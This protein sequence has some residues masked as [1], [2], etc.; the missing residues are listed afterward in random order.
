MDIT[1]YITKQNDMAK[2]DSVSEFN[3]HKAHQTHT[4]YQE[5][6]N[7]LEIIKPNTI[8][9][10]GTANG[11]FTRFLKFTVDL[12]DLETHIVS[13]D[14]VE[15]PH[16]NEIREA[17]VDVRVKNVFNYQDR[18]ADKEIIDLI[19]QPGTIL[20]LCDGGNKIAE[21]NTLAEYLK[22]G[23]VI[24]AH[25]YCHDD[26][27][28]FSTLQHRIWNWIEIQH[29]DIEQVSEKYNLIPFRQA[30]FS[31]AVWMCKLKIR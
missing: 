2:Y 18:T 21:V 20:V 23:D 16:Y 26:E 3:H 1:K 6:Y 4:A 5:F 31:S 13:Y 24:M 8:I 17:G 11:G 14:I 29:K 7:L 12:L 30:E 25:D 10:V 27:F 19:Q 28:Y 22:V 15:Q 9:E